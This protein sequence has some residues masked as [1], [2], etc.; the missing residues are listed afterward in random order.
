[1]P[2]AMRDP[3][4]FLSPQHFFVLVRH[5]LSLTLREQPILCPFCDTQTADPH[6]EHVLSC[7]SRGARHLMHNAL[8]GTLFALWSR[9]LFN[10][11]YEPHITDGDGK[12]FTSVVVDNL[13]S[14]V[15]IASGPS[16]M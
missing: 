13:T 7:T 5:R 16:Q 2:A 15:A 11:Q 4:Q 14:V 10:P 9:A 6:G 3:T 1:M 8:R 12:R